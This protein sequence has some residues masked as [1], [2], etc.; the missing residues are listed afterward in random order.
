MKKPWIVMLLIAAIPSIGLAQERAMSHQKLDSLL[1]SCLTKYDLPALG[2]AIIMGDT[3]SDI[4]VVGVRKYGDPTQAT[5]NDRWHIGSDTKSMTATLIGKLVETGKL[6]WTTTIVE[7]F[8][9][10]TKKIDS[11]FRDVPI[12]MLLCHRSGLKGETLPVGWSYDSVMHLAGDSRAQRLTYI[13]LMLSEEPDADPGTKYIYSNAGFTV[14]GAMAERVMNRSYEDLMQENVFR[15]LGMN[16]VHFGSMNTPGK[17]DEPWQ[18]VLE[19]GQHIAIDGG[20]RSDNPVAITPAGRVN[21]SLKDWATYAI[22]HLIGEKSGGILK[23]A[24]FKKLHSL[25]LGEPYGFG[26][27]IVVR[28]WAKGSALTHDGSNNQNYASIWLAPNLKFGLLIVTNEGGDEA[29]R[30]VQSLVEAIIGWIWITQ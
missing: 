28:D 7:V 17:L 1:Q 21:L 24:T 15:P 19:N 2:A 29:A 3:L 23:P 11:A 12:E 22:A 16:D 10:L 9:E 18:H 20:P 25:P 27:L 30:A 14:A 4:D 5:I 26:W 13:K 6:K 8:P